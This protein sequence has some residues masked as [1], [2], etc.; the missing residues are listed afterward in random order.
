MR[1]PYFICI[2]SSVKYDSVV[3]GLY[4]SNMLSLFTASGIFLYV[5]KYSTI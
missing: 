1:R 4:Q 5:L 3:P 2:F